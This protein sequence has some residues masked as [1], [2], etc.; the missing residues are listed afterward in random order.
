MGR[1]FRAAYA[2]G[3]TLDGDDVTAEI[4]DKH[5]GT[6]VLVLSQYIEEAYAMELLSSNAEGVGYLLK[7]RVADL[8]RSLFMQSTGQ[9]GNVLSPWLQSR[10]TKLHAVVVLRDEHAYWPIET[11]N[12]VRLEELDAQRRITEQQQR[13]TIDRQVRAC[14]ELGVVDLVEEADALRRDVAFQAH[15]G[16]ELEGAVDQQR[17][18][19]FLRRGDGARVEP[20]GVLR[21]V[22][23]EPAVTESLAVHATHAAV[24]TGPAS[25]ASRAASR[26]C[27]SVRSRHRPS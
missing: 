13:R 19:R 10:S 17:I 4:R 21:A 23:A 24:G 16:L 26:S 12:G 5:P 9:S 14:A 25:A 27:A 18:D 20:L 3:V 8:E 6:G 11:G 2:P 22:G 15:D 7:D 1:D